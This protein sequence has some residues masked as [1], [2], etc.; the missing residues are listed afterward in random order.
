MTDKSEYRK[1]LLSSLPD[2]PTNATF[3]ELHK[4]LMIYTRQSESAEETHYEDTAREIA[5]LNP[6]DPA[7]EAIPFLDEYIESGYQDAFANLDGLTIGEPVVE[8][9]DYLEEAIGDSIEYQSE[10]A[11]LLME[12]LKAARQRGRADS[13]VIAT[14]MELL[15]AL[16]GLEHDRELKRFVKNWRH[17]KPS[18]ESKERIDLIQEY[19]RMVFS[20]LS[21]DAALSELVAIR[22]HYGDANDDMWGSYRIGR[23]IAGCHAAVGQF[24][25]AKEELRSTAQE[26]FESMRRFQ[27]FV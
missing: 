19:C 21:S 20:Q 6:D 24:N 1:T 15:F 4:E 10:E 3:E 2:D 18:E 13:D 9:S 22:E 12:H 27:T 25:E 5:G 17:G 11:E 14:Q 8:A 26:S 7:S 23:M 16:D